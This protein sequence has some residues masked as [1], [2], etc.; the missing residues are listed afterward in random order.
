M[1]YVLIVVRQCTAMI[2][3]HLF[4]NEYHSCVDLDELILT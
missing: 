2:T 4:N 3:H 1:P